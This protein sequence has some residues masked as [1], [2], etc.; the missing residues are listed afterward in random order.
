M[1]YSAISDI[2]VKRFRSNHLLFLSPLSLVQGLA[3]RS[4]EEEDEKQNRSIILVVL[5]GRFPPTVSSATAQT[6]A[7]RQT[8]LASSARGLANNSAPSSRST[9]VRARIVTDYWPTV[10]FNFA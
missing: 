5:S 7:Y 9:V 3:I 6:I 2:H 1:S 10:G 4:K 8:N